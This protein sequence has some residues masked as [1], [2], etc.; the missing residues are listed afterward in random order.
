MTCEAIKQVSVRPHMAD[1]LRVLIIMA[2]S[3]LLDMF[4]ITMKT[5]VT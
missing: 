5:L 2:I 3:L 4:N 1:Y